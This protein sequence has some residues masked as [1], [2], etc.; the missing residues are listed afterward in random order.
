MAKPVIHYTFDTDG[1]NS[2]SLGASL[3]ITTIPSDITFD[4]SNKLIGDKA[5]GYIR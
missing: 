1:T 5:R 3:N 2:G 4:S